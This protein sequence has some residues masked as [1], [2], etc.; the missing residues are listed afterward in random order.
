MSDRLTKSE[1]E[2]AHGTAQVVLRS[3]LS[4]ILAIAETERVAERSIAVWR[5]I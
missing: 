4:S 1:L 2:T 3:Y 5:E